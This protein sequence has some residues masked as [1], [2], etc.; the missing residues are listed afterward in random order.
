M[1]SVVLQGASS[2]KSVDLDGGPPVR[3]RCAVTANAGAAGVRQ[4]RFGEGQARG[5]RSGT[6]R[7]GRAAGTPGCRQARATP[8]GMGNRGGAGRIEGMPAANPAACRGWLLPHLQVREEAAAG[9]AAQQDILQ[10]GP[11]R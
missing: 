7:N 4:L 6:P 2:S 1:Q 11:W 8:W 9:R 5:G 3:A 10:S